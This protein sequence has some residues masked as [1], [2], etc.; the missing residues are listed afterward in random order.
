LPGIQGGI[1][2]R[3]PA[4]QVDV[5]IKIEDFGTYPVLR[6]N[7]I[8]LHRLYNFPVIKSKDLMTNKW[9]NAASARPGRSL[10]I[11]CVTVALLLMVH[12]VYRVVAGDVAGFGGYLGSIGFPLG[13]PL[14]WFITVGTFAC[15]V[16]L[17]VRRL[18]VW[19]CL[20]HMVVLV[21]GIVLD[22]AH[23][24]W[25]VVG[26]GRNGVEY[27]LLLLVC[28]FAVLRSYWPVKQL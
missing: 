20:G 26:G 18:V 22:H 21:M 15:S 9:V 3:S 1:W 12:S 17:I 28:L 2:R 8:C 13:V 27:S 14:A 7:Y 23:D 11:I 25:F 4:V 16:A 5:L 24:G 10:D 19:A 6:E